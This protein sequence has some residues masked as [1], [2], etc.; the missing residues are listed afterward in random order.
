MS[1]QTEFQRFI[2]YYEKAQQ[3][4]KRAP[5]DTSTWVCRICGCDDNHACPGGCWWV[6]KDL[7]SA[8]ESKK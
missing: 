3:T 8:C 7:C 6:E 4:G 5:V 2:D 1:T